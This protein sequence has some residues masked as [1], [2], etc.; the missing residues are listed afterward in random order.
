[1]QVRQQ[2]QTN[3][4]TRRGGLHISED[5]RLFSKDYPTELGVIEMTSTEMRKL[6]STK[7]AEERDDITVRVIASHITHTAET[8]KKYYQHIQGVGQSVAAYGA[9]G[10]KR[11][12]EDEEQNVHLEPKIKL[13]R[14]KWL[15]REEEVL[16]QHFDLGIKNKPPSTFECAK[17]LKENTDETLCRKE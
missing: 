2:S 1:M 15:K 17:I 3:T 12:A 10:W 8:A 9:I 6:T 11:G 5:L 14:K 7:V 13:G 16:S 4:S